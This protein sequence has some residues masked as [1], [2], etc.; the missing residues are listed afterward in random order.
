MSFVTIADA[1]KAFLQ[2]LGEF[3]HSRDNSV[4]LERVVRGVRLNLKELYDA[5]Q[6]QGQS[7]INTIH[8]AHQL[9]VNKS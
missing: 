6:E 5:V 3:H 9:V 4:K 1:D 8:V 7:V 2:T